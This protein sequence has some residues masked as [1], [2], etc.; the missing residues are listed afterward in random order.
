MSLDRNVQFFVATMFLGIVVVYYQ[1]LVKLVNTHLVISVIVQQLISSVNSSQPLYRMEVLPGTGF[2]SLRD[3][4]MGRVL[5]YNYSQC[6]V[7][8]DGKYL[9]PDDVYLF[10]I[11]D[12]IIEEYADYFDH[13]SQYTSLTSETV[14]KHKSSSG[15]F[16]PHISSSFSKEHSSVKTQMVKY[17]C[18]YP[19]LFLSLVYII[20]R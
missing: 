4:D 16:S 8:N 10:P 7:S 2:D 19:C 12:S 3:I 11:R 15:W 20:A 17:E 1:S 6:R 13:W 5:N 14:S 9:L 18:N